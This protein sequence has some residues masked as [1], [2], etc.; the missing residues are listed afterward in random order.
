MIINNLTKEYKT[1]YEL[2]KALNNMTLEFPQKGLVFIVGVSGSG[3]STLMNMLS[4]VDQPT[5]GEVIV[6]NKSLFSENKKQLFGYRNSYVGLIFQDYNL[7][8]DINVYENI[9]LPLEFLGVEDYS[10]IDEVI[11]K[12]DI[13]DIK[14][15]KVTE[16]SSGQMQRVAI[17][18]ALVKDSAMILADEPTGNLDS[19]NTKIVMD[20]LK[21]ISKDRLV[22]VITHDDDAA[23][24]YGDRIIAIEDGNILDD[25]TK[26]EEINKYDPALEKS[27]DFV[28]PK[29][30]FHQQIKFTL[31]FIR[32]SLMR[33]LAIFIMLILIPII[34]NILCGYAFFDITTS[35]YNYQEKY[36]SNYVQTSNEKSG[37]KVYYSTDQ[38]IEKGDVYGEDNFYELYSTY[39]PL[40]ESDQEAHSFY[41]P[42]I[43]N[44]IVDNTNKAELL[45]GELPELGS[46][47]DKAKI[48]ITDYIASSY[49]Y[50]TNDSIGVGD[51]LAIGLVNYEIIGIVNTNYE[52]FITADLTDPM[53]S[54][55][56][57]ENLTVYNAIYT[58]Y[59]GHEYIQNHMQYFVEEVN[60]T[61]VPEDT[62]IP[63]YKQT[64]YLLVRNEDTKRPNYK[65]GIARDFYSLGE[66]S[67]YCLA[68]QGLWENFM[69][70]S[71][72]N[73]LAITD[74][75][76]TKQ[77]RPINSFSLLCFSTNKYSLGGYIRYIYDDKETLD[78]YGVVGEVILKS[79][80]FQKYVKKRA[81]CR[82]LFDKD[83]DVYDEVIK[84][85]K[86]VNQSFVY[87]KA[88]WDDAES[89]KFV[90]YEFLI[91]LIVIM[92]V[93]A[94]IINSLTMNMEKKKIGIKYSFG[95]SKLP[96]IIPYMLETILYILTGIVLSLLVVK[97]VY[98]FVCTTLI[99]TSTEELI[100]YEFFYIANSSI[101]GWD[102]IVYSIMLISLIIMVLSICKKSPIEIIK[103]L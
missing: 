30:T 11:K 7:I 49:E 84:N 62:S 33:S 23:H 83:C 42:V 59:T 89:S 36:G 91:T 35:Y 44:I 85:E 102:L 76:L 87:A 10:I 94:Y 16:I 65:Y 88:T 60:Y 86:I 92:A 78:V 80:T 2:V 71:K 72:N 17:A 14:Y 31:G 39:I 29:V 79:G 93:F 53:L 66:S 45:E 27:T 56:F 48:A 8:E 68:S 1:E 57:Q 52:D 21:E 61:V 55:A 18:R 64:G 58:S 69:M 4:G 81:G 101:L 50:Y 32:N 67:N 40:A 63:S 100:E 43:K 9:K 82:L 90:M 3:K 12:V 98:P 26:N 97:I 46:V 73:I 77:Y 22:I 6:G 74:S 41:Q 95:I 24:E 34:G 37:Y 15:S 99:Y 70:L 13:E 20:L 25:T 28:K 19:K 5:S 47:N 51:V 38:A 54:M 96:I 103:D 75:S